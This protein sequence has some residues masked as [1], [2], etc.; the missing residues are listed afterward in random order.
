[1]SR[2]TLLA[3]FAAAALAALAAGCS[4]SENANNVNNANNAN[5]NRAARAVIGRPRP[6]DLRRPAVSANSAAS[7]ARTTAARVLCRGTCGLYVCVAGT[8]SHPA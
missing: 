2:K 1:M 3:I 8:V 7:G 6:D 5:A 4:S